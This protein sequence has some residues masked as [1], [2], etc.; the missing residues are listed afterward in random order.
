MKSIV[1]DSTQ[2]ENKIIRLAHQVHENNFDV[3]SLAIIGLNERGKILAEK[4]KDILMHVYGGEIVLL[5]LHAKRN[6]E[7]EVEIA[8]E[9]MAPF[10]ALKNQTLILIDD[11]VDS[12]QTLMFAA[13]FLLQFHPAQMQ[14]LALIDRNHRK[15][16]IQVNYVG[17]KVATT[18]HE[19]VKLEIA[20]VKGAEQTLAFLI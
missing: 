4:I 7:K 11:V 19:R 15:F 3:S 9:D 12:G 10:D 6:E 14:T 17:H 13:S 2:I 5:H 16:P 1:L 18:L 20:G 8:L